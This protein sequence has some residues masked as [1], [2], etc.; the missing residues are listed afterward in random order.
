MQCKIGTKPIH[1]LDI[2]VARAILNKIPD[3]TQLITINK[4][5]VR[6]MPPVAPFLITFIL[7]AWLISNDVRVVR[8]ARVENGRNHKKSMFRSYNEM[9]GAAIRLQ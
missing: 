9:S 8:N 7:A 3:A 2:Y 1:L 4:G 6:V 5:C